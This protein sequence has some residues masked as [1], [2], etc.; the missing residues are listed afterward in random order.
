MN[1]EEYLKPVVI[2]KFKNKC[3]SNNS[4]HYAIPG[5]DIRLFVSV[6]PSY[7][8]L[9]LGGCKK[10]AKE[11]DDKKEE[12]I[13]KM[14]QDLQSWTDSIIEEMRESNNPSLEEQNE[15]LKRELE[16]LKKELEEFKAPIDY[17]ELMAGIE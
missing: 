5:T 13:I 3:S 9:S 8:S 10:H 6:Y 4:F 17:D 1:N 16:E 2:A 14:E 11:D 12:L 15:E 7:V